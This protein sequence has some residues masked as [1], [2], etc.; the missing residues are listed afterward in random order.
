MASSLAGWYWEPTPGRYLMV[1]SQVS[2]WGSA[3][4]GSEL[5]LN[6]QIASKPT[7]GAKLDGYPFSEKY[8]LR[9]GRMLD[10]QDRLT[11][12]ELNNAVRTRRGRPLDTVADAYGPGQDVW[13]EY[14][15]G[16]DLARC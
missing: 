2:Q 12:W 5:C 1:W 4:D 11:A 15:D 8:Y 9:F 6:F 10:E 16:N 13:L 14:Q 3:Q 7:P